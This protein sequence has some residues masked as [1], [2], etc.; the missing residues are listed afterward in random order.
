MLLALL[1]LTESPDMEGGV[2]TMPDTFKALTLR[3]GIP[4]L[5]FH[6]LETSTWEL[7]CGIKKLLA[8]ALR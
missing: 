6:A 8:I 4:Q 1:R 3:L 5:D 7:E 2:S